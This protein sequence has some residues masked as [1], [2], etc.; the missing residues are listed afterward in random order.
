MTVNGALAGLVAITAP[1]AFVNP[2]PSVIIGIIAGILVVFSVLCFDKIH[3][4]D[5][6]GALSVHLTNGI[7]GT[8]AVGL[9]AKASLGG[10]GVDGL[11]YGGGVGLLVNQFIGVIA[12]GAFTL[13]L[14]LIAWTVIKAIFGLRVE[15]ET[16]TTGLDIT[17]MGMEAYPSENPLG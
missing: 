15:Q 12:V 17:E 6:V 5:P 8:L 16:E 14:A 10:I 7:W 3:I 11:F 4:D 13:V 2:I 1:C 9:F